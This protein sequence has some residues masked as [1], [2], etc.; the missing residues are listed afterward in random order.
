MQITDDLDPFGFVYKHTCKKKRRVL[1]EKNE[2]IVP[3]PNWC[4]I[5]KK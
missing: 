3:V 4:P 5:L 1:T 2:D